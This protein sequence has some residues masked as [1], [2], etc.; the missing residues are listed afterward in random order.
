MVP[1]GSSPD[2]SNPRSRNDARLFWM[3]LAAGLLLALAGGH[4]LYQHAA[5]EV[6]GAR[7]NPNFRRGWPEYIASFPPRREGELVVLVLANSQG[8]APEIPSRQAY[9]ALL[10]HLLRQSGLPARVVNWSAP[11]GQYFDFLLFAAAARDLRPDHILVVT[12]TGMFGA[13]S[14]PRRERAAWASDAHHLLADGEFRHRLPPRHRSAWLPAALWPDLMLARLYPAWRWRTRPV[15]R[16][17]RRPP[18]L[19]L[20]PGGGQWLRTQRNIPGVLPPPERLS[21]QKAAFLDFA[22]VLQAACPDVTMVRMPLRSDRRQLGGLSWKPFQTHCRDAGLNALD[23]ARL[24]PDA[25]F[26]TYSHMQ[27]EGHRRVAAALAGL[28]Q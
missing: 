26:I 22:H 7:R 4:L 5:Q 21:F 14:V 25:E 24:V 28:F 1:T 16:A 2:A 11:A 3:L 27:V 18:A 13:S 19:W 10:Q 23:L 9:P 12:S 8:Y 17:A 15:E 6:E 20:L